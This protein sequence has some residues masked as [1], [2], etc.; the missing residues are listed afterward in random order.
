MAQQMVEVPPDSK[1]K[2][3]SPKCK[4]KE[5]HTMI[6]NGFK[7]GLSDEFTKDVEATGDNGDR[8]VILCNVLP[9]DMDEIREMDKWLLP[10][11][12]LSKYT[13]AMK[14]QEYTVVIDLD[15]Y[16]MFIND[17]K[18]EPRLSNGDIC[19]IDNTGENESP[20][21]DDKNS[22]N[23]T[24]YKLFSCN[25]CKETCPCLKAKRRHPYKHR[26]EVAYECEVCLLKVKTDALLMSHMKKHKKKVHHCTICSKTFMCKASVK[27][28][29]RSHDNNNEPH[30]ETENVIEDIMI[31]EAYTKILRLSKD[32][33]GLV[34]E[35]E[36]DENN[37]DIEYQEQLENWQEIQNEQE[38]QQENQE[39]STPDNESLPEKLRQ[40]K[41]EVIFSDCE[42]QKECNNIKTED[43]KPHVRLKIKKERLDVGELIKRESLKKE[44]K[45]KRQAKERLLRL[46]K[47]NQEHLEEPLKAEEPTRVLPKRNR[48]PPP[49]FNVADIIKEEFSSDDDLPDED[50]LG[51]VVLQ[52]LKTEDSDMEDMDEDPAYNPVKDDP[53]FY[54]PDI[55]EELSEPDSDLEAG[56]K[57]DSS[58]DPMDFFP[59]ARKRI[60]RPWVC[61]I[62]EKSYSR[63]NSLQRHYL[64][65]TMEKPYQCDLC[66]KAFCMQ[67]Y[68]TAHRKIHFERELV[69]CKICNRE[70]TRSSNL[71]A[72]MIIHV[73]FKP[74]SCRVCAKRFSHTSNLR[75][76]EILHTG[77]KLHICMLCG[78][79]FSLPSG[80]KEHMIIHDD[81][82]EPHRCD[83]CNKEFKEYK[84]LR[85]HID[86]H[87]NE[88]KYVCLCCNRRF[89]QKTGLKRHL[90][91]H[92]EA[93]REATGAD[94]LAK[95]K[96]HKVPIVEA[97]EEMMA[98]VVK[99]ILS[100][101]DI[102]RI[103][104]AMEALD[105]ELQIMKAIKS[106]VDDEQLES[107][108][109]YNEVN[110]ETEDNEVNSTS[111][112]QDA[113]NEADA[114][115]QCYISGVE[116]I[117]SELGEGAETVTHSSEG[118]AIRYATY[119]NARANESVE[120]LSHSESDTSFRQ[121]E[122]YVS[123]SLEKSGSEN[124]I[125]THW[126]KKEVLNSG[127]PLG[128]CMENNSVNNHLTLPNYQLVHENA[129]PMMLGG[130][131]RPVVQNADIMDLAQYYT[132]K[133]VSNG[134]RNSDM[135]HDGVNQ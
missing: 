56:A 9:C 55:K 82:A 33:D 101:V 96:A 131:G 6:E 46:K 14:G 102:Q 58:F 114:L 71:K 121:D 41:T 7:R 111:F 16:S 28:H 18:V 25:V 8:K 104:D 81:N 66:E 11:S 72:H 63:R 99:N 132:N 53:S 90:L 39:H 49:R 64:V 76:H 73:D 19:N 103:T 2:K 42:K 51:N 118:Y 95:P 93:E 127:M 34:S 115:E 126:I 54:I 65:H 26:W 43:E 80:L 47:R 112:T 60:K 123:A 12:S 91:T 44:K 75:R 48:K 78:K 98:P 122:G 35:N 92:S 21:K 32:A 125:N 20:E 85:R 83:H 61:E 116:V 17:E 110:S 133:L 128:S 129:N 113:V 70:F 94:I 38:S 37:C 5:A 86:L 124:L 50:E 105:H 67:S 108:T 13:C 88:K 87:I 97:P 3:K 22:G 120:G 134:F 40:V 100:Q 84:K 27:R 23:D 36:Q 10:E 45:R 29:M 89:H 1:C 68:L 119:I 52:S 117:E 24:H 69:K 31:Y 130:Y 77:L 57:S 79:G 30:L 74:F 135:P 109:E 4:H 107:Q 62:C 15:P 106:E 59:T